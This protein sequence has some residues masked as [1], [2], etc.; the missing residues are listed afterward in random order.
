MF[1]L[2]YFL[3]FFCLFSLSTGQATEYIYRDL[4]ANSLP[5]AKCEAKGDAMATA[6]KPYNLHRFTKRFCQSQGYGWHVSE[7][8]D[9]G[10]PV[11][12][13]CSGSDEGLERCHV[14]DIVVT[15]KLIRPGSVGML[16]GVAQ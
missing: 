2:L 12:T 13:P 3:G 11:C 4:M 10:K 15:C 14:E 1:K 9:N 7:I 16:P 5:S 8:K 6:S